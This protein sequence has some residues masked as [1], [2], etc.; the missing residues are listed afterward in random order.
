MPIKLI[1]GAPGEGKSLRML[2]EVEQ[3]RKDENREVYYSGVRDLL[4][5]WTLFGADSLDPKQPHD[6]D[7]SE[8][9]KVPAGAI[10]VIDECQRLFRP[11]AVG[12]KVPDYVSK[13]ETHRH[14]GHDIYLVTQH[15]GLI[16]SN[17][18]KL[19]GEHTHV[20]RKFGST[21]VTLHTWKGVKENCD[22]S[23]KDSMEEQFSYPKEVFGWYK[24]AEIHTIKRKIPK[25][26]IVLVCVPLVIAAA[27]G[28]TVWK[29]NK[30]S[31]SITT[32]SATGA[33]AGGV[34]VAGAPVN[35]VKGKP[36]TQAE[37]LEPMQPRI[38]GYLHTA[39]RFDELTKPVRVP[40]PVGCV[41][42]S[43]KAGIGSFCITQQGTKF[44]PPIDVVRSFVE[45][46]IFQDFDSG[47]PLP[48]VVSV[49]QAPPA[50]AQPNK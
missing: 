30:A 12:G 35:G 9:H 21:W 26:V 5:P 13:L 47:P 6:T 29:L 50:L 15:P 22:K 11:R 43:D 36:L 48:Q 14:N 46:G 34:A 1:T 4:L 31:T 45:R 32:V 3:R 16:D 18:R 44:E 33:P 25:K 40:V 37:Y 8:W 39:P 41:L 38:A 20:M 27:I 19:V 24:S 17:V 28:A 10:I 2:W 7:A 49:A 42:Y 23:R